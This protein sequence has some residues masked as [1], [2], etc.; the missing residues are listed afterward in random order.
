MKRAIGL[1]VF[2]VIIS[3]ESKNIEEEI[4]SDQSLTSTEYLLLSL[5]GENHEIFD[6]DK[7][8]AE[9][10]TNMETRET[11][12]VFEG[13][14]SKEKTLS[15]L[16]CLYKGEGTYH[17]GKM[18]SDSNSILEIQGEEWLCNRRTRDPG[19]VIIEVADDDYI[20]GIFKIRGVNR[21]LGNYV[22]QKGEF[23][24]KWEEISF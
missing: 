8:T 13:E 15:L 10:K 21:E 16:V 4:L 11:S 24:V 6:P 3:C 1:F 19:M 5:N 20:K 9:V 23:R 12:L 17:L 7:I 22:L 2:A 14:I 18:D